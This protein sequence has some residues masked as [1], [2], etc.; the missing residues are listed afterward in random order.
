[1]GEDEENTG[2]GNT[3]P[4]GWRLPAL[5][6][7]KGLLLTEPSGDSPKNRGG[8]V[9]DNSDNSEGRASISTLVKLLETTPL[10]RS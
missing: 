4:F 8:A 2:W 5:A 3:L 9:V 1:M 7:W 10:I 6:P